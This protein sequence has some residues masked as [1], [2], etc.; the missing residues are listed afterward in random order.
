MRRISRNLHRSDSSIPD[1]H[2]LEQDGRMV[3]LPF[4]GG[5]VAAWTTRLAP[6]GCRELHLYD[7]EVGAET[8][9]RVLAAE[10]VNARPNCRAFVMRKRSLE[11]Y[12]HPQA[13]KMATGIDLPFGDHDSVAELVAKKR[14]TGDAP[15]VQWDALSRRAQKRFA[16]QSK[17]W[18]NT[19]VAEAMTPELLRDRDPHGEVTSWLQAVVALAR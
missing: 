1:L 18:L 11:N 7:R 10:Q 16:N 19:H 3:F 2:E 8:R 6:L 5:S 17:R 12:L 15:F 9:H 14:F 4:G 13:L